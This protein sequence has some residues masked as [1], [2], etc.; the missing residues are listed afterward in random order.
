MSDPSG[1]NKEKEK[2]NRKTLYL[3]LEG[4]GVD[5][6]KD[7]RGMFATAASNAV[8]TERKRTGRGHVGVDIKADDIVQSAAKARR[9]AG[10]RDANILKTVPTEKCFDIGEVA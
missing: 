10:G 6:T 9:A 5:P 4:H 8:A 1:G 7:R 3:R 2:E